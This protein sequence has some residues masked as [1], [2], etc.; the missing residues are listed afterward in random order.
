MLIIRFIM[1]HMGPQHT[2]RGRK[3]DRLAPALQMGLNAHKRPHTPYPR[4]RI[5]RM[6][7][8]LLPST[9]SHAAYCYSR[10]ASLCN[11]A[12][13]LSL[14]PYPMPHLPSM[15]LP[16]L[17][18]ALVPAAAPDPLPSAPSQ[19]PLPAVPPASP[20]SRKPLPSSPPRCLPPAV[21]V[22]A[23]PAAPSLAVLR[24]SPCRAHPAFPMATSWPWLVAP[25][26]D[27]TMLRHSWRH[28]SA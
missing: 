10:A 28:C 5:L 24:H 8:R 25:A 1:A 21:P 18:L 26:Q 19:P 23:A 13:R 12:P 27:A 2:R 22:T 4:L 16:V 7:P 6:Q 15:P 9:S 20:P 3:P 17:V 11:L 14:P